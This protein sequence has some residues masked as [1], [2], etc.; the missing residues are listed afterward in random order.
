[1]AI[2]L[3]ENAKEH[4]GVLEE[5]CSELGHQWP[6]RHQAEAVSILTKA[7]FSQQ[8]IEQT[9]AMMFH[10]ADGD[11]L[12][13]HWHSTTGDDWPI[14]TAMLVEGLRKYI[15]EFNQTDPWQ[16]FDELKLYA[17]QLR[18]STKTIQRAL[19]ELVKRGLARR[20]SPRG[21]IDVRKSACD[22]LKQSR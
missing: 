6:P 17:E 10:N 16:G 14:F 4:S 13:V 20:K 7:G 21:K 11:E 15:R 18:V 22:D 2:R 5:L 1:M 19:P 3:A 9:L 12:P 8:R